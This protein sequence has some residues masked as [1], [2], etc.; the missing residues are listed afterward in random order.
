MTRR[1]WPT[2]KAAGAKGVTLAGI[3]CTANEILMRHGIPVAGNFLQQELA[4]LTG[5]VEMMITDVQCCMP[6]LP[7]VATAYHTK[8]VS[9]SEIAKTIGAE[10][11]CLSTRTTRWTAPRR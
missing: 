1:S 6:S 5:A 11:P 10:Q 2:P 9:T 8:V 4:I 3:C 7:E